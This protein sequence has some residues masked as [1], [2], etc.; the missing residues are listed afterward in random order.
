[1]NNPRRWMQI[2]LLASQA[3]LVLVPIFSLGMSATISSTWLLYLT[4]VAAI[5]VAMKYN[6]SIA[7]EF[8][9][10]GEQLG[11]L[12][13]GDKIVVLDGITG[14]KIENPSIIIY[15]HDTDKLV[16]NAVLTFEDE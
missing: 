12:T 14:E 13:R 8:F 11:L 4:I 6:H 15:D 3:I 7:V 1:M 5:Y 10:V 16:D 9:D 2:K